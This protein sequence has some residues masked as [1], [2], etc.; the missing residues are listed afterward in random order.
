MIS[1]EVQKKSINNNV[2]VNFNSMLFV[3]AFLLFST[4]YIIS[5]VLK[6]T[7]DKFSSKH[8]V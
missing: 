6:L 3:L 1:N 2:K 8:G 7:R 5:R 4:W